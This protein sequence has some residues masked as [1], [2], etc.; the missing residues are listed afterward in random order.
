ME[1]EYKA[2]VTKVTAFET[3]TGNGNRCGDAREREET[4]GCNFYDA[5]VGA[6]RLCERRL[7]D[8]L[9]PFG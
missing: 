5:L 4:G 9:K 6:E 3:D 2:P 7:R 1:E 8:F